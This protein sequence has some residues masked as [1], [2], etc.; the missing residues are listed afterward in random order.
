MKLQKRYN[1]SLKLKNQN[2]VQKKTRL[3]SSLFFYLN[4][5]KNYGKIN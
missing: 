3:I 2:K 1:V 4:K 5:I